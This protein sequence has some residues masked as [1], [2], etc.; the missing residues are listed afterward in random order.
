MFKSYS[1]KTF[2]RLR[3]D[4]DVL[5]DSLK[6]GHNL[7]EIREKMV[8][9][10]LDLLDPHHIENRRVEVN[11]LLKWAYAAFTAHDTEKRMYFS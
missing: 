11:S 8:K 7:G 4:V 9:T 5:V 6:S 3:S 1:E 2:N 10:N